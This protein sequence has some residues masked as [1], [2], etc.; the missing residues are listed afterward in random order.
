M[1]QEAITLLVGNLV[2][3][4]DY[5]HVVKPCTKRLFHIQDSCPCTCMDLL[6]CLRKICNETY[7]Q[8][9]SHCYSLSYSKLCSSLFFNCSLRTIQ[10]IVDPTYDAL[11]SFLSSLSFCLTSFISSTSTLS[12][13]FF[14]MIFKN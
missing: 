6:A 10:S 8:L 2:L 1:E 14:H 4:G 13:A 7:Y 11:F 3:F 9:P 12:M 5:L